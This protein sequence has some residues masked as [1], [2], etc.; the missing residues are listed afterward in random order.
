M[1]DL[2]A[3]LLPGVDDGPPGLD[4]ALDLAR[5]AVAAGIE[6]M[7]ATPHIDHIHG[8]APTSVGPEV[9]RLRA[10]LAENGI[11]LTVIPGGEV[12]L[13]R[14]PELSDEELGAVAL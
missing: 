4:E 10:A 1:I 2:H 11:P 8:V 6:T 3:H 14:L 7:A 12:A 5:G 13:T 9:E